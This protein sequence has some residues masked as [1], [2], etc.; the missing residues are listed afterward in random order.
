MLQSQTMARSNLLN[1]KTT[2]FLDLIGIGKTF[3]VPQYQRDY[4][5]Q[6]EAWED[7][8]TD[9]LALRGD[10]DAAHYMG[11]LVV[12]AKS[13]REYQIIDGQQ[14]VAT[15]SVLAL[16]IIDRL[17]T[18]AREGVDAP[19]NSERAQTLRDRFIGDKDPVSLTHSSKLKLNA[20]DD[21]F[22]QDH[23]VQ[24]RAPLS[25]RSLSASNALL[26]KCFAWFSAKIGALAGLAESGTELAR[27]LSETVARQLIFIQ[28]TVEDDFS[29]YTVFE[30]LN[31]RGL[32]LSATDLLK[33]Y[34]FSR[35]SAK[36][37]LESLQRRWLKLM[38]TV[39]QDRFPNFLRYH[40]L[41]E[42]AGIRQQ[43]LF[44]IVRDKV[45]SARD[46]FALLDALERRAEL[47]TALGDSTHSYWLDLPEARPFVRELQLF[48]VR[49]PTPLFFA[50]WEKLSRADFTRVLK[51][52]SVLTFR[53]SV[54]GGLNPNKLEMAYHQAAK[55]VLEGAVTSLAGIHEKLAEIHVSDEKFQRDFAET[56][57]S[58]HG[59]NR[60][61]AKYIL[62]RLEADRS[63]LSVDPETDAGSIEHV[64]PENPAAIWDAS[65]PAAS[66][67][68]QIYRLGNLTL[69]E[70]TVN[71]Q[72]GNSAYPDKVKAYGQ[73]RYLLTQDLAALAPDEWTVPL[74]EERQRQLAARAAHIWRPGV[75]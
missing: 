17:Q 57:L 14:R 65:I 16:A 4:S 24:L 75:S 43:R 66:W 36:T 39:R 55:A 60:K 46:V 69:L 45:K 62:T 26:W 22:F 40:L 74:I 6:E 9:I 37:D 72:L 67:P 48:G 5:W 41:C 47:F 25:V 59:S 70:A 53:Y 34:L 58:T 21:G 64:L 19:A 49:Q 44:K 29:A 33:N 63:G 51:L 15:L 20:A 1:A 61:L 32:E 56:I 73:S 50:C 42:E 71:R 2:S 8:W 23:L 18:L 54:I 27:L 35:V 68:A 13:D 31:A 10:P 12:E 11:A 30:T 28:I 7:L 3:R 38:S 52:V